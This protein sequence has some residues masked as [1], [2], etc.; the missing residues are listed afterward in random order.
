MLKLYEYFLLNKSE[1]VEYL[2]KKGKFLF[3]FNV[4]DSLYNLYS[5]DDYYVQTTFSIENKSMED[6]TAFRE[7]ESLD[8]FLDKIHL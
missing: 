6:I 3:N 2:C 5:V 7:G 8:K 1:K 4:G